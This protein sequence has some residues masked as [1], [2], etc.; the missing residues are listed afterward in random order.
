M[1][2]THYNVGGRID[3]NVFNAC[4]IA[5]SFVS[6]WTLQTGYIF[7]LFNVFPNKGNETCHTRLSLATWRNLE[8]PS[9]KFDPRNYLGLWYLP[10]PY[11]LLSPVV[12][13]Q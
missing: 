3:E 7:K 9:F 11:I 1:Y 2:S 6:F 5:F 10:P 8:I 4:L 13:M 12:H